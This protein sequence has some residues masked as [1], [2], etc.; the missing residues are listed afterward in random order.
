MQN[1]TMSESIRLYS[2]GYI[3]TGPA[4]VLIYFVGG[5]DIPYP[6]KKFSFFTF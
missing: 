1:R 3:D 4:K 6:P 2:S 5:S